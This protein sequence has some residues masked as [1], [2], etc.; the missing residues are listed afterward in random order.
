MSGP[1]RRTG[2]RPRTARRPRRSPLDG[3]RLTAYDVLDGVTARAAYANLLLPQLLRERDLEPRDAA[4]ATQLAYGALR[5]QGT[6]DAVLARLVDRPL[7]DLDPRVLD[8]LR[9]GTY[10][11]LDLRVPA[12]AAVDT[13]VDLTR[14]IVGTGA[15][16][17]VNA[18]LRKVAAGGDRQ[19][20]LAA[21]G[22]TG[23]EL[24]GLATDHPRWIVEAW[25]AALANAGPDGEDELEQALL[26]DDAAPQVHLAARRIDR[27][28][29]AREAG[30]VP[31]PWSPFAVRLPGGDPGRLPAVRDGRAAVQDEGSQLAALALTRPALDG[32]DAAW[33]DMCA[34]PGGKAGLLAAVRPA[35]VRLTAVDRAPHRAELV[36]SALAGAE[37]V[38]VLVGDGREPPWAPGSFDR[39]LLDAPCTGLGALR[40]RPEVRW[41]RTA[42]DVAPLAQLQTELLDSALAAV[43][44]GGLV[45]YVTCSPHQ[46]ETVAVVAAAAARDDVEELPVAPLFPEVP[47]IARGRAAQLWPH[48]HGTDAMFMALLRRTR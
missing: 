22:A 3:A 42:D 2:G 15:S 23:D 32:P 6:L 38:E 36:R 1:P 27:D 28:E 4:F 34:G 30:G 19:R 7:A 48:R 39:V 11:L 21:L 18:V 33:L 8:L 29:L 9:L 31:G 26:A 45:A 12:H 14:A 25:R 44:P 35:G 5:A 13:T 41:R 47:G 17:L 24:L 43:R 10:Q 20:W 46:A 40:R 37:D 16:G